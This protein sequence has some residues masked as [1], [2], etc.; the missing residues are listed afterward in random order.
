MCLISLT[1][2][3]KVISGVFTSFGTNISGPFILDLSWLRI[4]CRCQRSLCE[5]GGGRWPW[6]KRQSTCATRLILR[7]EDNLRCRSCLRPVWGWVSLVI[8]ACICQASWLGMLLPVSL[9]PTEVLIWHTCVLWHPGLRGFWG[10]NSGLQVCTANALR[11]TWPSSPQLL[12]G[13]TL[14]G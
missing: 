14:K 10:T 1:W 8:H 4:Y 12:K 7:S 9:L 13:V 3:A 6:E 5:R 2:V 11:P